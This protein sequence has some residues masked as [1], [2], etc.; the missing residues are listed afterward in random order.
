MTTKI[1]LW[2]TAGKIYA[3]RQECQVYLRATAALPG[4]YR[5]GWNVRYTTELTEPVW[6]YMRGE[7]YSAQL[8]HFVRSIEDQRASQ[9]ISSF[10][11]ALVT[12]RSIEMMIADAAKGSRRENNGRIA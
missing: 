6:F 4:G 7:E 10:R 1:T 11:D 8:D 3:D 9:N 5:Q 12:D 2:G